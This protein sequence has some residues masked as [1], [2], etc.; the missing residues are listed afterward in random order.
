MNAN[1]QVWQ[2]IP[3]NSSD[4]SFAVD[5]AVP[6]AGDVPGGTTPAFA[7]GT[8]TLRLL[9]GSLKSGDPIRTLQTG[10]FTVGAYQPNGAPDP[11]DAAD[12]V[13]A[14]RAGVSLSL[15]ATQLIVEVPGAEEGEWIFVTPYAVDGSPRYPWFGTWSRADADGRVALSLSGATLPVGRIKVAVQ[16]GDKGRVGELLGWGWLTVAAPP[17]AGGG[18]AAEPAPAVIA[19]VKPAAVRKSVVKQAVAPTAVPA[20]PVTSGEL[21]DALGSGGVTGLQEGTVVTLTLPDRAPGDWVYLYAYFPE[22]VG[23]GWIQVDE[24]RQ[25][26]VDIAALP[27]GEHRIAVLDAAGNLVGWAGTSVQGTKVIVAKSAA[28]AGVAQA[29]AAKSSGEATGASSSGIVSAADWWVMGGAAVLALGALGTAGI[30]RGRRAALGPASLALVGLLALGALAPATPASALPPSGAGSDTPGTSS[31]VSPGTLEPCQTI[32]FT[33]SG[34]P[35]GETL[36]VKIDDGVGYGDTS[37]QG[38]GVIHIQAIPASGTVSGSFALPCDISPGPHWL[39]YLASAPA[40]N[41]PSGT[42]G[43]TNRGGSDFTVVAGTGAGGGGGG[44]TGG[45]SATSGLGRTAPAAGATVGSG[46]EQVAG[47]GAILVIDPAAVAAA[48]KTAD[49]DEAS[50][51]QAGSAAKTTSAK[52]SA[53]PAAQNVASAALAAAG[54]V[55]AVP[56]IGIGGAVV[57]LAAGGVGAFALL[58]RRRA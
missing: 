18:T 33:V 37:V 4:G 7:T 26:R 21:L 5:I 42:I 54:V 13:D 25:V 36:S 41:D 11:L 16:S 40:P 35:A 34:F 17:S 43:Y 38:S 6:E 53:S 9:T 46:A 32:G 52:T 2:V 29:G 1:A 55:P 24:N 20:A 8:H 49:A 27:P 47:Q 31:S 58:K 10:P 50:G 56:W 12:L 23:A 15:T 14:N 39:R 28:K 51:K 3:V 48:A 44:V 45:A 22:P 19:P 30:V 57:I